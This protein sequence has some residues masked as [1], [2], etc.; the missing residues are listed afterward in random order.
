MPYKYLTTHYLCDKCKKKYEFSD[1]NNK[2][3]IRVYHCKHFELKFIKNIDNAQL[4]YFL[5][6]KCLKCS[7]KH[8]IQNLKLDNYNQNNQIQYNKYNCCGNK[9]NIGAFFSN[10]ENNS[11]DSIIA[12]LETTD[13]TKRNNNNQNNINNNKDMTLPNGN[14]NNRNFIMGNQINGMN[15]FNNINNIPNNFIANNFNYMNNFQNNMNNNIQMSLN[16][17]NFGMN[18]FIVNNGQNNFGQR[19]N[20]QGNFQNGCAQS[21]NNNNCFDNNFFPNNDFQ[22]NNAYLNGGNKIYMNDLKLTFRN[23]YFLNENCS[24]PEEVTFYINI[25]QNKYPIQAANNKNTREVINDFFKNNPDLD[26]YIYRNQK[27]FLNGDAI[28]LEK[29]LFQNK[30]QNGSKI[31]VPFQQRLS[32]FC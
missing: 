21:F 10:D 30:I 26:R 32:T 31:L 4:N 27:Y 23:E 9:I 1:S 7:K 25:N 5:K 28:D 22:N 29:T 19:N 14:M 16:N 15:N 12:L 24:I 18:G 13:I 11:I 17:N 2:S 8:Q 6:L 3:G 20:F